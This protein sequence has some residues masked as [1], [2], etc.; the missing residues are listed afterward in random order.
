ML[1]IKDN[2]LANRR[3]MRYQEQT[4]ETKAKIDRL[5][6]ANINDYQLKVIKRRRIYPQIGDVFKINPKNDIILYGIVINNHINN[7]NGDDLILILIFRE[8]VSIE[9]INE[10]N[11]SKNLL[12]PPQIVGR[13][14]WTRGYF[15]NIDMKKNLNINGR[16]A[17]YDIFDKKYYDEYGNELLSGKTYL[18]KYGHEFKFEPELVGSYGVCTISGIAHEINEELIIN[19]IL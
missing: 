5:Y 9:T 16:I 2:I 8:N 15:Y 19:G 6:N 7:I 14:Y 4:I 13:E 10:D 11:F 12:I 17:F 18:D 1:D 3:K